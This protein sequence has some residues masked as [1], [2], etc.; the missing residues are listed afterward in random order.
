M[1]LRNDLTSR[2]SACSPSPERRAPAIGFFRQK[3]LS[4]SPA[5]SVK[6]NRCHRSG[7]TF[8]RVYREVF[9][10]PGSWNHTSSPSYQKWFWGSSTQHV[11]AAENNTPDA[12]FTARLVPQNP[13]DWFGSHLLRYDLPILLPTLDGK[14]PILRPPGG[15]RSAGRAQTGRALRDRDTPKT[16]Y[17]YRPI[18][19]MTVQFSMWKSGIPVERL[20][21][22]RA[23]R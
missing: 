7:T 23:S 6:P 19:G 15:T 9:I 13:R 8:R 2:R 4:E 3:T 5:S 21:D 11:L 10:V 12:P 14:M 1:D 18:H 16:G 17:A 22:D 20:K